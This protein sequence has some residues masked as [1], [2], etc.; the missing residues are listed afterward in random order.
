[1]TQEEEENMDLSEDQYTQY[2]EDLQK[3][4]LDRLYD[5]LEIQSM[6]DL[7]LDQGDEDF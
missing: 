6:S 3:E 7:D 2:P 1:M 5:Q 4:D